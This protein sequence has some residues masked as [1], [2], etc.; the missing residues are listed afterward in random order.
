V[1]KFDVRTILTSQVMVCQIQI[2]EKAILN[3]IFKFFF[4]LQDRTPETQYID[5]SHEIENR[6]C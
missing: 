4:H 3:L 5:I 2:I 1:T 6:L